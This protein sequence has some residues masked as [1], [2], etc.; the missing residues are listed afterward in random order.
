MGFLDNLKNAK[1][2]TVA[3]NQKYNVTGRIAS[4]SS[5]GKKAFMKIPAGKIVKGVSSFDSE[6]EKMK[7]EGIL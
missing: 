2:K 4:A 7:K 5:S 6:Y 3:F 1:N